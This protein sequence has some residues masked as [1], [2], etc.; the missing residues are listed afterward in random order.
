MTQK[1]GPPNDPTPDRDM[2]RRDYMLG[3]EVDTARGWIRRDQLGDYVAL[4]RV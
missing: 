1:V 2:L 4:V 3:N